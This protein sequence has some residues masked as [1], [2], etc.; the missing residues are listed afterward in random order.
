MQAQTGTVALPD[1]PTMQ[2]L[3]SIQEANR[4]IYELNNRLAKFSHRMVDTS[5]PATESGVANKPQPSGLL[6][7][8]SDNIQTLH[9]NLDE[10]GA[11]VNKIEGLF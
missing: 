6:P 7:D 2:I 8:I 3:K 11:L 1:S 4:R 9:N 10:Y 5:N